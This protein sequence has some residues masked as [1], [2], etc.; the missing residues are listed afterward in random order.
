MGRT[1]HLCSPEAARLQTIAS[2]AE[3]FAPGIAF[4]RRLQLG[5]SIATFRFAILGA[6][7]AKGLYAAQHAREL[8][9]IRFALKLTAAAGCCLTLANYR[10]FSAFVSTAPVFAQWQ[11]SHAQSSFR[12]RLA[13]QWRIERMW[14]GTR[15]LAPAIDF[16]P[17]LTQL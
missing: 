1:A 8:L 17:R 10:A 7:L 9:L 3:R 13:R 6:E 11:L 16:A 5:Q 4:H 2:E 15:F 12:L 14:N